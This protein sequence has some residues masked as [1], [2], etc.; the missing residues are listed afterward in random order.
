MNTSIFSSITAAITNRFSRFSWSSATQQFSGP[1]G[2]IDDEPIRVI[3]DRQIAATGNRL[4]K[5][6][7]VLQGAKGGDWAAAVDKWEREYLEELRALH[8]QT[9]SLGNGGLHAMTPEG[10]ERT[11]AVL[12]REAGHVADVKAKL[13]DDP[14]YVDSG[15]FGAH[16]DGYART[17]RFTYENER[18]LSHEA[19]GFK[20]EMRTQHSINGC[21][22]CAALDMVVVPIGTNPELG[23]CTCSSGCQC[24]EQYFMENPDAD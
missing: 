20:F 9:G 23:E 14:D 2:T 22:Q 1:R 17:A 18:G 11:E 24:T 21:D 16:G 4:G 5:A 19:A 3:V 15:R 12:E 10:Y 6:G 13:L 8:L 7:E